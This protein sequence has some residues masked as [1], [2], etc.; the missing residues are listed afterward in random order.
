M[1]TWRSSTRRWRAASGRGADAIGR[2]LAVG[3]ERRLVRVV[4]V[5]RDAKYR[6]ITDAAVSNVYRPAAAAFSLTLL[7]RTA[8]DPRRTLVAVQD[9]LDRVG[10]GVVGF[11]PRTMDDHLAGEL[12]PARVTAAAS[13]GL[14]LIGL[15]LSGVGLYGL[16][17]WLVERRRREIGVRLALGAPPSAVVRMV[18][19]QAAW[20][21]APGVVAGAGVA[22]ALGVALR[23]RLFG[24]S[25]LDLWAFAIGAAALAAVVV[26][27]AWVPSARAARIDP[28]VTLRDP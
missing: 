4:G 14:G 21:A 22:A 27:A 10:P 7:V 5:A 3:A 6:S 1:T 15:V 2:A 11:F 20:A 17:A 19:G 25:P 12:L 28:V 24:V 9:V 26:L 23:A 18:V 13:A 8:D 16:V